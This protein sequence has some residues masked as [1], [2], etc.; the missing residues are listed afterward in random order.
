LTL[1]ASFGAAD[2]W[3][4]FGGFSDF[5]MDMISTHAAGEERVRGLMNTHTNLYVIGSSAM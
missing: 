3:I 5:A 4:H 1:N 2:A